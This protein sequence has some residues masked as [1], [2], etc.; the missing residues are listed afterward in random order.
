MD[1]NLN[2]NLNMD[3]SLPVVI[4]AEDMR[5]SPSPMPGVE[6]LR[7]ERQNAESGHTT[8]IVRY[9]P[10]SSFSRHVHTGGEEYLVLDG[11]FSDNT[12]DFGEGFYVRNPPGSSHQPHCDDGCTIFVKLCQMQREG[13]PQ[14]AINTQ[15]MAWQQK[16]AGWQVKPLFEND[17]ETV[18]YNQLQPEFKSESGRFPGGIEILLVS[19]DLRINGR[20]LNPRSWARY[21]ASVEVA[22]ATTYGCVFW[23][24]QNHLG[25]IEAE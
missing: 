10:G 22:L 18:Q 8:S 2:T 19:G 1:D 14:V 20:H 25:A 5:W 6:R 21:P 4:P 17:A 12:G 15:E 3:F 23:S 13:E 9:A 24:K 11:T 16:A 7:L